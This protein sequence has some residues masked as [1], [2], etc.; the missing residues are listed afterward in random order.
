MKKSLS[1]LAVLVG[2]AMVL[3]SA[4]AYAAEQAHK[5]LTHDPGVVGKIENQQKRI[6]EGVKKGTLTSEEAALVQ[7]NLNRIKAEEAKLKAAGELTGKN[8]DML[9]HKLNQNSAMIESE[10]KNPIRRID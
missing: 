3:F 1:V 7:D 10:R 5:P 2:L 9:N 4:G 6:D 8:I